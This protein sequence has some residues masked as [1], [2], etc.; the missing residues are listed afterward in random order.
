MRTPRP[1]ATPFSL[2][3]PSEF[4][5]VVRVRVLELWRYPVKSLQGEQLSSVA[6]T[7]DGLDGDR[8][9]AIFDAETG[10]GLT[11]RRVPELLFASAR[12][13]DGGDVEITLPDGSTA[14]DDEALS[15]W[16]G[17]RVTLRSASAGV[18]RRYENPVDFERELPRQQTGKL[19]KRLLRDRY[20]GQRDSRI[21]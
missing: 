16:L 18:A 8:R 12:L 7:S 11:G 21:V 15:A 1:C 19:Y 10:F 14:A 20:W 17:R 13:A 5:S 2:I 3:L 9:F 4:T 6:I